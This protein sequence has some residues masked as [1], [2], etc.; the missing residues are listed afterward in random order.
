M[1]PRVHSERELWNRLRCARGRDYAEAAFELASLLGNRRNLED[2]ECLL[3]DVA[4]HAKGA[5]AAEAWIR[6]AGVLEEQGKEG[7]AEFAY[8]CA[9]ELSNPE[10]TPEV[11]LDLAKHFEQVGR[12]DPALI[13][14]ERVVREAANGQ[15][16]AVAAFR[17]ARLLR[18]LGRHDRVVELLRTALA[19]ASP[20]SA[21]YITLRLAEELFDL[22]PDTRSAEAGEAEH[23]LQTVI[24][25]DH[26]DLA[27]EAALL[28]ARLRQQ[29]QQL[30]EAYRLCQLCID[31][32]HPTYLDEAHE[33]QSLL[34][35]FELEGTDSAK[36]AASPPVRGPDPLARG[37]ESS[38]RTLFFPVHLSEHIG[39]LGEA[40]LERDRHWLP[41][42]VADSPPVL[43]HNH[44]C[45]ICSCRRSGPS[46]LPGP[47]ARR[48]LGAA[49]QAALRRLLVGSPP[50]PAFRAQIHALNLAIHI[51]EGANLE[52]R[53]EP[54]RVQLL[55]A[56]EQI[57]GEFLLEAI[58][59]E[60]LDL[61]TVR[62]L[63]AELP[64]Q[65][66]LE[67][68][69]EGRILVP[70]TRTIGELAIG[71]YYGAAEEA[72]CSLEKECSSGQQRDF[73]RALVPD[74]VEQLCNQKWETKIDEKL[75]QMRLLREQ[76]FFTDPDDR[77]AEHDHLLL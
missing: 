13:T 4:D 74:Y 57:L 48:P 66:A 62:A 68:L 24:E 8:G 25:T 9:A 23:L 64:L 69:V 71:R 5:I 63:I 12:F 50:A 11:M 28:L 35:H 36:P 19:D 30:N 38:N 45:P 1:A 76:K 44:S 32:A 58:E 39:D 70:Q 2:A 33:L 67:D 55:N 61:Q 54:S 46:V 15:M 27:P 6:L 18:E 42:F 59:S 60:T 47:P 14:Y 31:S 10:Q 34:L 49:V 22:S 20:A 16:R 65:G 73:L 29:Q 77:C 37:P 7:Y 43:D 17:L 40:N 41:R 26:P 72:E 53:S 56:R 52:A 75:S 51:P 3:R 21:I